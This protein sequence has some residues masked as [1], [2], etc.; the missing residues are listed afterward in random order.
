MS[1]HNWRLVPFLAVAAAFL[2]A[3][4]AAAHCDTLDGPVVT[5]AR[6]ALETGNPDPVLIWVAA[7]DEAPVRAAFQE[8]LAVRTLGPQVRDL[9]DRY[10]F[11]TVVRLHRASEGLPYTG[12]RPA[13]QAPS[14]AIRLADQ[15]IES[16]SADAL[17]EFLVL[18]VRRGVQQRFGEVQRSRRFDPAD[19]VAGRRYVA[20]YVSFTHYVEAV[21]NASESNAHQSEPPS[22]HSNRH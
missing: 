3:V 17:A 2:G 11:E 9:A 22:E 13:G 18:D 6:Q 5:A 19:L 20:S 1:F 4:P 7:G 8:V 12:L 21:Q 15:A 16:G 10:F 14:P